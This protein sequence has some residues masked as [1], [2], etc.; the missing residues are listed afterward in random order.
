MKKFKIRVKPTKNGLTKN[1]INKVIKIIKM[2][3]ETGYLIEFDVK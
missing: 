2:N 1:S 3:Q